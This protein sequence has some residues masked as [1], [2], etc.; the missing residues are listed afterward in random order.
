MHAW[1]KEDCR[2][3]TE[4]RVHVSLYG[5][6]REEECYTKNIKGAEYLVIIVPIYQTHQSLLVLSKINLK[7]WSGQ[8]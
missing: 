8:L 5:G 4:H 1:K 7:A 3:P 6:R 2:L